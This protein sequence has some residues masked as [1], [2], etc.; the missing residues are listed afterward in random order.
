MHKEMIVAC[1]L[2]GTLDKEPNTTIREFSTLLSGLEE[3]KD[4]MLQQNCREIAMESTG[5]YW[6]PIYNVLEVAFA[7][8]GGIHITVTNPHHMKNVPGKKTDIN[9]ARWIAGLLRA[10][11][12]SPSYI[13]P[14][15]IRELRDWIRYR[16]TLVQEM[17]GHK[18]RIEKH[19]QQCGFKLST[20]LTDIFGVS[21]T[22]I[23]RQ[24]CRTGYISPDEVLIH[25]HGTVRN[26]LENIQ[27]AVNGK[28]DEHDRTFLS[29]LVSVYENSLNEIAVVENQIFACA[30]KFA[31]ITHLIETIP[32]VQRMAAISIISEIGIDLSS[33]PTAA[34][35]CSWAGLCPGN[36][37]SAGKKK[38]TRISHGNVHL[39]S[40][41]CQSAWAA[42][43]SKKNYLHDWFWKLARRRGTRKAVIALGRKMLTI[44][45]YMLKTGEVYDEDRFELSKQHQDEL[46]KQR[47]IAEAHK[48]GFAVV[49]A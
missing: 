7:D 23:I 28:M 36:N 24:L 2:T 30:E 21:G 35:F 29:I 45:Y 38:S 16:K 26:K 12:L 34:H 10:G 47:L 9:D 49:P 19:L 8:E 3:F 4:W 48:L 31:G 15:P 46:R 40:I 5:V 25:L 44:I 6:Y 43:K 17:T 11:L 32:G 33:F 42:C 41:I 39:K 14:R 1:L 37:E 18:N 22:S 20:F 27:Q 13:P